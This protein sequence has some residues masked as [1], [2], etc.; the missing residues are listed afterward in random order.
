M[1]MIMIVI[2]FLLMMISISLSSLISIRGGNSVQSLPFNMAKSFATYTFYQQNTYLE[3]VESIEDDNGWVNPV[4]FSELYC[5][6]DLPLPTTKPA[7][8]ICLVQGVPRYIMPSL[9]LSL[10]TPA[11]TWRNRGL[12]SLPR[13]HSWIDVF[14]PYVNIDSLSLSSYCKVTNDVRFL[15]DQDGA[16]SWSDLASQSSQ[17]LSFVR[18]ETEQIK[19]GNTFRS[20]K[21]L[22]KEGIPQLQILNE[23]YCFV[24]I[25][26]PGASDW[27][28]GPSIRIKQYLSDFD[29]PKR[30]LEIENPEDL[31]SEP[32]GML[33]IKIEKV[34]AGGSSKYLPEVYQDLYEEGNIIYS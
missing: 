2:I 27:S 18:P 11:K 16:S 25:P 28:I 34:A 13:A 33:D 20:F 6:K 8:G 30:L 7:L 12:N 15:E 4:S 21:E 10:E 9:V 23:G 1:M 14:S 19:I 22:L 5:P 29:D 26:I 24:D 31:N 32:I 17:P 3:K